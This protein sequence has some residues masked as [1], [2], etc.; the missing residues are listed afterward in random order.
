MTIMQ[1]IV[2]D[3]NA[4]C[5]VG[6]PVTFEQHG[7][8]MWTKTSRPAFLVGECALVFVEHVSSPIELQY[9]KPQ[10]PVTPRERIEIE[11][12]ELS[13]VESDQGGAWFNCFKNAD[14][15]VVSPLFLNINDLFKWADENGYKVK[16]VRYMPTVTVHT[17]QKPAVVA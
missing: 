2:D 10:E 4:K 1:G 16:W 11:V 5:P 17:G 13:G 12:A 6:T 3:W 8:T 7:Q 15:K 14:G 9:L